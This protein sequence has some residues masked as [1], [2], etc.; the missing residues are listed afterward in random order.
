[1]AGPCDIKTSGKAWNDGLEA[2]KKAFKQ[3]GGKTTESIIFAIN[4]AKRTNPDFDFDSK[5]F[6]D[7]LVSSLKEKG[8]VGKSYT[9]KGE[10]TAPINKKIEKISE[11]MTGLSPNEKKSF[12]RKVFSQF[13]K[14]GTSQ[15][16]CRG[17]WNTS[18]GREVERSNR[19]N[20]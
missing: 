14:D 1:M 15:L 7:P 18:Y 10:R 11:K 17:N 12:G 2:F 19:Q 13:E 9:F 8:I 4:E 6:V 16:I 20:K 3:T 5:T